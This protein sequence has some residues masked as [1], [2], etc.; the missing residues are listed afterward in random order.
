LIR[1]FIHGIPDKKIAVI[2]IDPTKRKTGG[3]LLG[4]RI[5]MNAIFSERVYMR[6]LATRDSHS[7]LSKAIQ[8][9]LDVVRASGYDFIIVETSGIGQGDAAITDV[10]DLSMYVMTA[11]FGAPSQLEKIDMI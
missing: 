3:A 10:T 11:E 6:S 1:R 5:R 9:V 7:E 2:S 4:D 8:D